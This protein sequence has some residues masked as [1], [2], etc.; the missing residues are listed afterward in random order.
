MSHFFGL[1]S[2]LFNSFQNK[3]QTIIL[4]QK[5]ILMYP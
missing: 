4:W 5:E 1:V 3:K 2:I